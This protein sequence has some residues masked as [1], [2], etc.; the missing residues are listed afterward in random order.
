MASDPTDSPAT[1][2][3][4]TDPFGKPHAHVV[5]DSLQLWILIPGL[6]IL[7][8]VGEFQCSV[9]ELLSPLF[10]ASRG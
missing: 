5:S 3:P 1:E 6:I 10:K 4:V 7:V 9:L 2:E 8:F